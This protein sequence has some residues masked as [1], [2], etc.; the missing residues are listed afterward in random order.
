MTQ[1]ALM[2][3]SENGHKEVV[4]ILLSAKA[5]VN[6]QT[7][8]YEVCDIYDCYDEECFIFFILWPRFLF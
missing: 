1:T 8:V 5:D 6:H 2:N 7:N 4:E 3:A